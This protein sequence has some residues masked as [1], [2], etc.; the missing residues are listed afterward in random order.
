MLGVNL[1]SHLNSLAPPSTNPSNAACDPPLRASYGGIK[2][3]T[4]TLKPIPPTGTSGKPLWITFRLTVPWGMPEETLTELTD[5]FRHFR[6][7]YEATHSGLCMSLMLERSRSSTE[8]SESESS[9]TWDTLFD[10]VLTSQESF[11]SFCHE[12]ANAL[13]KHPQL[14]GVVEDMILMRVK[15]IQPPR[16]TPTPVPMS[17]TYFLNAWVVSPSNALR[18]AMRQLTIRCWKLWRRTYAWRGMFGI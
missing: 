7:D 2:S 11:N 4:D 15:A 3:S 10:S 18:V 17:D 6:S 12:F 13:V 16:S 5:Y 14:L 9:L 1:K 8:C